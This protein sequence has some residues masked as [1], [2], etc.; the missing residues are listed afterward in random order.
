M[1]AQILEAPA[2]HGGL[3]VSLAAGE[4]SAAHPWLISAELNAGVSATRNVADLVHLFSLLH[5]RTPGL[6][7]MAAS[8]S[9]WAGGDA[10]LREAAAAFV[11][12][13]AFLAALIAVA[14]PPPSTPGD[15]GTVCTI[16]SQYYSMAT[17]ARSERFGCAI[18]AVV[19]LL[20]DWQPLRAVMDGAAERLGLAV[21]ESR[22]PDEE[23]C[24]ALLAAM[25]DRPRLDRTLAFGARQVLAHH[26]GLLDYCAVR[27]EAREAC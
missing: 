26:T 18:G 21:P 2:D 15:S 1:L 9:C 24:R 22:L 20:L 17:L 5:G 8:Q 19:T 6:I 4:G 11:H 25:P 27:A 13:R 16:Q 23:A 3:M 12:E 7:D 14:G 10:F